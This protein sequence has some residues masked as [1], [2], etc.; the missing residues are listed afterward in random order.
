MLQMLSNALK[1]PSPLLFVMPTVMKVSLLKEDNS[2]YSVCFFSV[3]QKCHAGFGLLWLPMV[4]TIV[5]ANCL[6]E[7]FYQPFFSLTFPDIWQCVEA[8]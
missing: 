8:S 6:C 5:V 3:T 4:M 2:L 7:G 1:C